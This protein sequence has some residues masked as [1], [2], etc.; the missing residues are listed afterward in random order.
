MK[1][2]AT[3]FKSHSLGEE[4]IGKRHAQNAAIST[5]MQDDD[6]K[7]EMREEATAATAAENNKPL[8]L[9]RLHVFKQHPHHR[10]HAQHLQQQADQNPILAYIKKSPVLSKNLHGLSLSTTTNNNN[11][12]KNRN[13][14]H[15][16]TLLPLLYTDDDIYHHHHHPQHHHVLLL[17]EHHVSLE[18]LNPHHECVTRKSTLSI[19]IINLVATVCGGGVLTLPMAFGRAG[20]IPTTC[21]LVYAS[22]TTQFGLVCLIDA[23]RKVG[24]R[25]YGDVAQ[26]AFGN[27]AQVWT[28]LT[29]GLL[30][31]GSL[32]AFM[33]L[34]KDAWT[35]LV[36]SLCPLSVKRWLLLNIAGHD[37]S[38]HDN[39]DSSSEIS[40]YIL[41]AILMASSPLLVKKDLHALRHTCYVGLTSCFLLMLAIVFRGLETLQHFHHDHHHHHH[42]PVSSSSIKSTAL[43]IRWYSTD[44]ADLLFAFPIATFC[45]FCSFNV[46]S[47]HSQLVHPT[48][49]RIQTV[50]S[51]SMMACFFMFY[52]VGLFGY[53]Y[54]QNVNGVTPDNILVAFPVTD[55]YILVGRIGYCL[56]LVFAIPLALLPCREALSGL[57][58]QI[59]AWKRDNE[60]IRKY[61][62]VSEIRAKTGPHLIIN[63]VDFDENEPV[64]ISEDLKQRHGAM[65]YGSCDVSGDGVVTPTAAATTVATSVETVASSDAS[66]THDDTEETTMGS[67]S[68]ED[69]VVA[70]RPSGGGIPVVL[71]MTAAKEF[72]N[73]EYVDEHGE[74]HHRYHEHGEN[75]HHAAASG[76]G[77]G[78]DA[79]L[80]NTGEDWNQVLT[81]Y[82]CTASIVAF[83]YTAAVLVPGVSVIWS[84]CGSSMA[85]W[86]AFIVPT[87]CFLK[88]R[89]HKGLTIQACGAWILLLFSLVAMVICTQEAVKNAFA[90]S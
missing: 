11:N 19:A 47:I 44:P 72:I 56:T 73:D 52:L 55:H 46:L 23:A 29:L 61:R 70:T 69:F 28:T 33:V 85:V 58:A 79:G 59:M 51:S 63:G 18:H 36:L 38:S 45:F 48:R 37:S 31:L 84:I 49:A 78:V 62:Q 6:D 74:L 26:A 12:N 60:L 39:D 17:R 15:D 75:H 81:H 9:N 14:Q 21:I 76:G 71:D 24:G 54:A 88:I 13:H 5:L 35:Q 41:A 64:L 82:A 30:L 77:D 90:K 2:A 1:T 34:V 65:L 27:A 7:D 3:Y 80:D 50:V 87:A 89:E 86:I 53:V 66:T 32:T 68:P 20:I 40:N 22:T 57:P 8:L 4:M 43:Q 16:E 67:S 10:H 42:H 25:S 83:T